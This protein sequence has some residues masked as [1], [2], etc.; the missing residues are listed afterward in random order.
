MYKTTSGKMVYVLN[1]KHNIFYGVFKSNYSNQNWYLQKNKNATI[2][3]LIN[4]LN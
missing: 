3:F 2:L 1:V 4:H